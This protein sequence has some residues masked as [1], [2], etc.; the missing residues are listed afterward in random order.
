MIV[1]GYFLPKQIS[2]FVHACLSLFELIVA[3]KSSNYR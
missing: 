3:H 1:I 2:S